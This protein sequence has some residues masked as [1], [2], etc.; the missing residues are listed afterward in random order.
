MRECDGIAVGG[1]DGDGEARPRNAAGERHLPGGGREHD[2]AGGRTDVDAAVL[3]RVVWVV[4]VERERLEDAARRGP[5][6]RLAGRGDDER[7]DS[8]DQE[9]TAHETS[10]RRGVE[11]GAERVFGLRLLPP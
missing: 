4:R 7:G 8:R 5:G 1:R 9:Q 10:G 2:L 3:A 6:P 11:R